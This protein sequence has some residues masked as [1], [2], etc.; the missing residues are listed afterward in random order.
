MDQEIDYSS[1]KWR[2]R[3]KIESATTTLLQ[4]RDRRILLWIENGKFLRET[5]IEKNGQIWIWMK[6]RF[7]V[8]SIIK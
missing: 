1:E 4:R 8:K 2:D 5:R 6:Q 7:D 3:N